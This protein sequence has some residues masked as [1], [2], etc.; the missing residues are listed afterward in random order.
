MYLPEVLC[1]FRYE[2]EIR[3]LSV[4]GSHFRAQL[5]LVVIT[6]LFCWSDFMRFL[7]TKYF[8]IYRDRGCS[9]AKCRKETS[10]KIAKDMASAVS[11]LES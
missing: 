1:E 5:R 6:A 3:S 10:R 9:C 11:F 7:T 4:S 8:I 2:K